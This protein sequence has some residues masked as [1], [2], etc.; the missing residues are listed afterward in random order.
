MKPI[1]AFAAVGIATTCAGGAI[2]EQNAKLASPIAARNHR[3]L[4]LLFL[5]M[6]PK[7]TVLA[8]NRGEWDLSLATANDLR[9]LP[10]ITEDYEVS[11]LSIIRRWGL[12]QGELWVEGAL[13][14]RGG[15]F[16]DPIIDWWHRNILGW[17]D[18]AR[19]SSPNGASIILLPDGTRFASASGLGDLSA[20]YGIRLNPR[21]VIS[22][23][24]KLPT[25]NPKRALGSGGLDLGLSLDHSVPIGRYWRL[26]AQLAAVVQGNATAITGARGLVDQECLSLT[27]Q[28]NSRDTWI[29]QWQSERAP[30]STG[31]SG[32]DST[33]RLLVFG[34]R[35]KLG[36][37][38]ILELHL[39]EDRD[40]FRGRFPEAVNIGP[41]FGIGVRYVFRF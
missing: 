1:A 31:N 18:P 25:G 39:T 2:P 21:T 41:D 7:S 17:T 19:T 34:Y 28:P 26:H 6:L 14:S 23:A 29:A 15:G 37:N 22:V 24:A 8:P 40:V 38:E 5:R 33:H 12:A 13:L 30:V 20:G 10:G 27:F 3:A 35:R 32:A 4:S 11:R 36:A 16:L 9:A